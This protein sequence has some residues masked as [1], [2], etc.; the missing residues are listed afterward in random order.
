MKK[1]ILTVRDVDE[2]AWRKFRARTE[3][4]GLKTGDALSQAMITWVKEK[5]EAEIEKKPNPR[6][7]LKIKPVTVGT[8]KVVKWSEEIDE[9]LYGASKK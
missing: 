8:G 4:E 7:L 9:T 3:Q 1:Q 2:E 6:L 5:E